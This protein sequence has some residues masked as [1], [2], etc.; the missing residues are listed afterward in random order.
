MSKKAVLLAAAATASGRELRRV[1]FGQTD[2]MVTE[3]CAGTMTW[4]SFN[5]ERSEAFEQLDKLWEMGVNFIDTA[6]MYPVA[7]NYGET[8]E[9]W[10]GEWLV[11]RKIERSKVVLATKVNCLAIGSPFDEKHAF[12][13][14]HV[15]KACRASLE[16]LQVDTID[17]YQLHFPTRYGGGI[18]GWGSYVPGR[19][20]STRT[21]SGEMKVFEDQVLAV[22][23]LLDK[24]LIKYWGLSNENAYGV[25]MFC[26]VADKLGV[27]RPV[28]IQNDFSLNNRI[29]ESDVLEAAE[30]FGLVGLH[31]GALAGGVLTGKYLKGGEKYAG[32][33]PLHLSRHNSQPEFQARYNNAITSM[34]A[35]EYVA[36]AEEYGLTPLQLALAWARDRS[37]NAAIIIGTTTTKQVEDCVEAFMLDPLSKEIVDKIDKIHEKFRNPQAALANK[38]VL[39]QEDFW[40]AHFDAHA[41]D[42]IK[43]EECEAAP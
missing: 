6:E 30:E 12:D 15:E 43:K 40:Q 5:S 2:L 38:E 13:S 7:F 20:L 28:S 34:A 32:D 25:T 18:F 35:A 11:S 22:K 16:R 37:Y 39:M 31:Y 41:S 8:S 24:G 19:Y 26:T 21:S 29:Y 1:K 9:K 14:E 10:I 4:G 17:L 36:L 23:N 33:R 27:P 42:K 3:V